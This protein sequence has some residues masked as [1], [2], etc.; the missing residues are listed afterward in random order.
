MAMTLL[1]EGFQEG[2]DRCGSCEVVESVTFSTSDL[3]DGT[4][5][6][7]LAS[8]IVANPDAN[9]INFPY[10]AAITL[11]IAGLTDAG[12]DDLLVIGAEG[13]PSQYELLNAGTLDLVM[14]VPN[15]WTGWAAVDT[16][17]R[18]LQDEPTVDEGVGYQ[19]VTAEDMDGATDFEGPYDY[20][21]AY[22]EIWGV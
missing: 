1:G 19:L 8:A 4:Y 13:A 22:R 18:V 15:D 11:G 21:A 14:A 5:A 10:A 6:Q 12:R 20:R 17:N 9:A 16:L 3:L 2:I 7:K